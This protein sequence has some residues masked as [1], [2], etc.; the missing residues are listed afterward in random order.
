MACYADV[1]NVETCLKSAGPI[2]LIDLDSY[3]GF[4]AKK[5]TRDSLL[6]HFVSEMRAGHAVVWGHNGNGGN[7]VV[8]V[9]DQ[10]SAERGYGELVAVLNIGE[11]GAYLVDHAEL[12]Q[13]AGN[14]DAPVIGP[15]SDRQRHVAMPPGTYR[16][17]VVRL[18]D[19]ALAMTDWQLSTAHVHFLVEL[20]PA[21]PSQDPTPPISEVP[22]TATA[23]VPDDPVRETVAEARKVVSNDR[24]C[25]LFGKALEEAP[26][27]ADLWAEL[28]MKQLNG[29]RDSAAA[30][31]SFAKARELL[32]SRASAEL[33]R[34]EAK[35]RLTVGGAA[36][37]EAARLAGKAL[38]LGGED[39][40]T[41]RMLAEI[42]ESR[43]DYRLART[44]FE[45]AMAV[46]PNDESLLKAYA[47]FLNYKDSEALERFLAGPNKILQGP[48]F[49]RL[50]G[51]N[52]SHGL[53]RYREAYEVFSAGHGHQPENGDFIVRMALCKLCMGE[54][55]AG[56]KLARRALTAFEKAEDPDGIIEALFYLYVAALRATRARYLARIARHLTT[57]GALVKGGWI[58][59]AVA[60][61]SAISRH[62][63]AKWL[64]R[65]A[66]VVAGHAPM[67]TLARWPAW[68]AARTSGYRRRFPLLMQEF[69][70]WLE[71]EVEIRE[72]DAWPL[73]LA[74]RE[75]GE[76]W[77]SDPAVQT[78]WENHSLMFARTLD[79]S[80]I[81]LVD[82]DG[83]P[84]ALV[85]LGGEG[86]IKTLANSP[87]E[88]L[89]LLAKADT[90]VE[91][92]KVPASARKT[93]A[94]WLKK[95]GVRV[96]RAPA[97]H[98]TSVIKPRK[99]N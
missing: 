27:R 14:A 10:A 16:C 65:L 87:E 11:G 82:R 61:K 23:E 9:T 1:M 17:R 68:I 89:H 56:A 25:K 95:K 50:R 38:A 24:A 44:Y 63:E 75:S 54:M 31:R 84:T 42:H 22:W 90:G 2:A 97:F 76:A 39:G 46:L 92:D 7:H 4:V 52:L 60:N 74:E 33:F 49:V 48:Y 43:K 37:T 53:E 64:G 98:I 21:I 19:P 88:F 62:S 34:L 83:L 32:G 96:P 66:E 67:K 35:A 18:M 59:D 28:G 36:L 5:W 73:E 29:Q 85:Y 3:R 81:A 93:L 99:R 8:R 26:E 80:E 78:R 12:A 72:D 6:A 40:R 79:G 30:A 41:L 15:T 69:A 91:L 47:R 57:S 58:C 13:A 70:I 20:T 45:R 55:A 94:A 51:I 86:D 71:D 77:F